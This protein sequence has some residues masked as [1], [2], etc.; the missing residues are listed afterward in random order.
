MA[1]TPEAKVKSKIKKMLNAY[2]CYVT[3]PIGTGF[4]C[5]GVPDYLVCIN[6]VFLGIEAKAGKN[7]PTALQEK[8]MA[9]IRACG[10]YTIVVNED[11]F[12]ELEK[13]LKEFYG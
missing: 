7:K 2:N 6:G 1:N 10:G 13:L 3:M 12:D 11:N 5:A 8:H 9:D 4:G